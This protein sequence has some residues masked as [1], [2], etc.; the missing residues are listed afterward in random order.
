M[1]VGVNREE[2]MTERDERLG[3]EGFRKIERERAGR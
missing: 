2:K 3:R 1:H